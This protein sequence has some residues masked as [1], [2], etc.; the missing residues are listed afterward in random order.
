MGRVQAA[1]ERLDQVPFLIECIKGKLHF[2]T[3][4]GENDYVADFTIKGREVPVPADMRQ[5]K[6]D[7]D[8]AVNVIT[9]VFN[10]QLYARPVLSFSRSWDDSVRTR[11]GFY[12]KQLA[13]VAE[14]GLCTTE[15]THTQ[16]AKGDLE[17]IKALF[18][19]QEGG[20]IKN[21]Y[22]NVLFAWCALITVIAMAAYWAVHEKLGQ[23]YIGHDGATL[24]YNLR[25]FWALA[26]GTAIGTWL[27][28]SLRKQDIA[29]KD[30]A[31]LE[32]DRLDPW[33]RVAF[34]VGL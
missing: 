4:T 14:V 34:M 3:R 27:S 6:T 21:R 28:F 15:P 5:L 7:I 2:P 8:G 26:A 30:L 16:F 18:K 23:S 32:P 33:A 31:A 29:F 12:L 1:S 9:A 13:G 17:R 22:N 20:R 24:L 11:Q 19:L 10:D 25:N